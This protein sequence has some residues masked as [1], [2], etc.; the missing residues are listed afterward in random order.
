MGVR[1][2]GG[3]YYLDFRCN[4]VRVR[5]STKSG[6][7]KVANDMM[8][9]RRA[10]VLA[11]RFNLPVVR[12]LTFEDAARA[13]LE[14]AAVNKASAA[15]DRC[16]LAKMGREFEGMQLAKIA[17]FHIE[18]LKASLLAGG[19]SKATANRH[20]ACLS[21]VYHR[22]IEAGRYSG[23]NP[24]RKVK[25][26]RE[27]PGRVRYLTD[28]EAEKLR[29]ACSAELWD[30]VLFAME[31]GLRAGEQFGLKWA[32][33]DRAGRIIHVEHSKNGRR[34]DVPMSESVQRIVEGLCQTRRGEF[35][36]SRVK[37]KARGQRHQECMR[38]AWKAARRRAGIA[39]L[40]WHDLRHHFASRLTA[41]GASVFVLQELMGHASLSM[42]R[43]YAHL[44]PGA[45]R[46]AIELLNKAPG[47]AEVQGEKFESG[48][49]MGIAG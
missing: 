47:E 32:N 20:L 19:A 34:R 18:K 25:R 9:V 24:V 1:L 6:N 48:P 29:A 36:F 40:R 5:E 31:T 49:K 33:V 30:A 22:M 12:R 16:F 10:E 45:H 43:R 2:I 28:E 21:G 7:L 3:T 14:W 37:G 15:D 46:Q 41:R 42:T 39:D 4:G 44:A 8:A 35:V 38:D 11:G 26:L 27:P 13:Y 23:E 17:P